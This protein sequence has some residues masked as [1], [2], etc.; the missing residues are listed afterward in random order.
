MTTKMKENSGAKFSRYLRPDRFDVD[1]GA[2]SADIKWEHWLNTFTN[3]L[4]TEIEGE[5]ESSLKRSILVNHL[6]SNVYAIIRDCDD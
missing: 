2:P 3:F 6:S 5:V 1:P 4:N